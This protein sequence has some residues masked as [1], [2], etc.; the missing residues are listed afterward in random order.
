MHTP[1]TLRPLARVTVTVS[2]WLAAGGLAVAVARWGTVMSE[3]RAAAGAMASTRTVSCLVASQHTEHGCQIAR[4]LAVTGRA[5]QHAVHEL[6]TSWA[7]GRC[8]LIPLLFLSD[9]DHIAAMATRHRTPLLLLAAYRTRA[10]P[11][12]LTVASVL[13]VWGTAR[14]SPA[15]A[16]PIQKFRSESTVGKQRSIYLYVYV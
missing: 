13:W 15:A 12:S 11:G 14:I 2:A 10:Y 16:S 9:A 6:A 1:P 5:S 8:A 4:R 3:L 7:L